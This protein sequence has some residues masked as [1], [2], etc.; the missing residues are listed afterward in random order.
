MG[1][2]GNFDEDIG[3]RLD[4]LE[5]RFQL[6][7]ERLAKIETRVGIEPAMPVV[8]VHQA[9]E[10]PEVARPE[11]V[12]EILERA[13]RAAPPAP[14]AGQVQ[15][16]PRVPT[17]EQVHGPAMPEKREPVP[18]QVAPKGVGFG[19]LEDLVTG[20][21][22]AWVGGLALII[23]AVFF[24]SLAFSRGWIGPTARVIIGLVTGIALVSAGAWFFERKDR[25]F[26]NVLTPVGLG[27][28]SLSFYA[29]TRL[30]DL[31]PVELG[32]AGA[33]VSAV[34]VAVVAIRANTQ[35]V[36]AY[37]LVTALSAP[38]VLGASASMS[39]IGFVAAALIGTTIVALYRTWN[40]LPALAFLLAAPQVADYV[41]GNVT[42]AAGMT[43]IAAFWLLNAVAA[44]GEEFRT[45]RGRLSVTS[46]T[47]LVADAAFTVGFGFYLLRGDALWGRGLFLVALAAAHLVLGGYFLADRGDHHPF[48]MLAF[49][50]GIAAASM[51]L[52]VQ[53]GGP[54]VPIGWAAEAAALAWVYSYR[55]HGYSA[56]MSFAL[57]WMA[58]GHLVLF[59]YPFDRITEDLSSRVPFFNANGGTLVF[60]LAAIAVAILVMRKWHI[61]LPMAALG[62]VLVIYALPFET[63]GL[64]LVGL[65]SAL[66]VV[67][68]G[69]DQRLIMPRLEL[70]DPGKD[71]VRYTAARPI[72]LAGVI[73]MF[74]GIGHLL[75][76][77]LGENEL[78]LVQTSGT[79]F[80][81]QASAA[82]A[83][84]IVAFVVV[85]FLARSTRSRRW[86]TTCAFVIAAYLVPFELG[87][88]AS[89][90]AWSVLAVAS[91]GLVRIDAG[92][93]L[94][95]GIFSGAV[96][97]L[98][99]LV[100]LV[101]VAPPDRLGVSAASAINHPIFWSAATASIGSVAVALVVAGFVFRSRQIARVIWLLAAASAVYLVS[102]GAV[103]EFQSRLGGATAVEE[104]QKQAQVTLSIL[105]AVLGGA[106]LVAGLWRQV[107]VVRGAGLALLAIVTAKVFVYDLSS[108]DA[109]YRV[110]SFIGLGVLLL[111]VAYLYQ[112]IGPRRRTPAPT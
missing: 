3:E 19:E 56:L 14:V 6:I 82:A 10:V 40:W 86:T 41:T 11:V 8:P 90:V 29:G 42:V 20:R 36:A 98:A 100:A 44:G 30:Y 59:E 109:A 97:S 51:A 47:L 103:D 80:W 31:V 1:D 35:L 48:G 54:P 83:I 62:T 69:V 68:V 27:V 53:L 58:I 22:L 106:A 57:G 110:L 37:G 78:G 101:E 105:W 108:L 52:P 43:A 111:V 77:E 4:V 87:P 63:S 102:I 25:L 16:G 24:L 84:L 64:L 55:K 34:A 33:L 32:L 61:G 49:G 92:A 94:R 66:F 88:A 15:V 70:P 112:H 99:S 13:R 50:T 5:K 96:L 9:V 39:T 45:R 79:P 71:I 73:S 65:W 74:A 91:L 75:L 72:L 21:V 107:T 104:L 26:G 95:Y 60:I 81:D 2:T 12:Q 28:L 85:G 76:V 38:I 18:V 93:Y 23:G 89:V 46:T 17:F 7:E 67:L